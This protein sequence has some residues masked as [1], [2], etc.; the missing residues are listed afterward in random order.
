MARSEAY[1]KERISHINMVMDE[2]HESTSDIYEQ[3][4]DKEFEL[5]KHTIN[6]LIFK[7]K[8]IHNSIEDEI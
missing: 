8:E 7:L 6:K 3:L 2:I 1:D 4:V 5:L